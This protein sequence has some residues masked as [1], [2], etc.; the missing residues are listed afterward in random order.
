MPNQL[1]NYYR[2]LF[3]LWVR[4]NEAIFGEHAW[5]WH[6]S[7]VLT[8]VLTTLLLYLLALRLAIRR[9]AALLA[10]LIFGLH[11]AHI[12]AVA[13]IS[14]VNEPLSGILLIG[15]FLA[16]LRAGGKTSGGRKWSSISI[17]LYACALLMKESSLCLPA[18]LL[19]YE[20]FYRSNNPSGTGI[21][22]WCGAAWAKI[23]PYLALVAI[24]LPVRVHAL[25]GFSHVVAPVTTGQMI[26]TWPA[27]FLFWFRHLVWP[28]GLSTYYNF[29][30]VTH[31]TLQNFFLPALIVGCAVV[32]LFL[33]VRKSPSAAFFSTWLVLPLIPLLNIRVFSANDFAH[34]RYLYLPSAGFAVLAAM[35]LTHFF[36]GPPRWLGMPATLCVVVLLLSASMSYATITESFYFRDNL[37]FYAYNLQQAPHHPDAE[38]N[39]ASVLA[40][41]GQYGHAIEAFLDAVKYN[42]TYWT[43]TYNLALTYYKIGNLPESEKYFLR[44]VELNPYKADEYFYLGVIR[45]KT[46]RTADG[47]AYLRRAIGLNPNGFVYHFAL[48]MM[49]KTQGDLNGALEQFKLELANNPNQESAKEQIREIEKQLNAVNESAKPSP[50][51]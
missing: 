39:Y 29:A 2:P 44:A 12:E 37:T 5:G 13:W 16:Y 34:D 40:E 38:S 14:G 21:P 4:V 36:S 41:Q 35:F 45:F 26:L 50:V 31:A 18:L 25:K 27:L 28:V 11:P 1:I 49:L 33:G 42:P 3:L 17:V 7:T 9:D 19:A 48:G 24:Y 43:P 47:V 46:G 6:L 32:V 15:S 10:A 20:W 8:H 30:P 51:R 23:W 22:G